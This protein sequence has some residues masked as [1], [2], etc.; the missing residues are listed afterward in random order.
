MAEVTL[1]GVTASGL[2]RAAAFTELA[3]VREQLAQKLDLHPYPG[4]FNVRLTDAESLARWRAIT[5]QP[6]VTL[7]PP[8]AEACV[9]R[10][11]PVLLADRLP[12]AIVYPHVDRYPADQVEV[13]SAA[14]VRRE[15]GLSDGDPVTLRLAEPSGALGPTGRSAA[16][17]DPPPLEGDDEPD[18]RS[19]A[20]DYLQRHNTV[21]L[22]TVGPEGPWAAAVF[23]VN[24]GLTLYFLSEPKTQHIQ[25]VRQHPVVAA[26]V[27]E[28]YRDWREIKGIQ[29][30]GV[31][32]EVTGKREQA[33]ALAAYV[34]KFP[35]VRQFLSPGQL[36]AGMR[37]AGRGLDVRL[38]RVVPTRL[39]Y[40]DNARGFSYREEV[41]LEGAD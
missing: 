12:G 19:V 3:W 11:Y 26:T 22:A 8:N 31:C 17:G 38:F 14:C 5:A 35:F 40:L 33:R 29:M 15:L 41:P 36:L 30:L 39:L 9:A 34:R 4:T 32:S 18:L 1:R 37:I 27:N 7:E 21:S 23:Y 20:L 28:D 16:P 10:C 2:G 13:L 6:G 25:N 24:I